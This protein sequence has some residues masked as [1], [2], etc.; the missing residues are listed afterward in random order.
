MLFRPLW[1][2]EILNEWEQS[3]RRRFAD[4]KDDYFERQRKYMATFGEASVEDYNHLIPAFDL[5]DPR[6]AHVLAAAVQGRADAI[7]TYNI[8]D[9]PADVAARHNIEIRH[10]DDFLV[11]II[12]LDAGKALTAIRNQRAQYNNPAVSAENYLERLKGSGLIQA[13]HRLQ[14]LAELF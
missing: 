8:K 5:P 1:S 2:D 10:P 13:A 9:F 6:D 3:L 7:V 11:N 12:D 14:P 4:L